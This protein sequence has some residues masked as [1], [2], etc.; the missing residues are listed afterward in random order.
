MKQ[1]TI[2]TACLLL[3]LAACSETPEPAKAVPTDKPTQAQP[4]PITVSEPFSP[5]EKTLTKQA[6]KL[7]H[8]AWGKTKEAAGKTSDTIKDRS[9][10]YYETSKEQASEVADTVAEKS[11]EYYKA[12]KDKSKEMYESAADTASELTDKAKEKTMELYESTKGEETL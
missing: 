1:Q 10:Q 4:A 5:P 11:K 9:Q 7:G 8:A 6:V 12:A 3:S 2:W